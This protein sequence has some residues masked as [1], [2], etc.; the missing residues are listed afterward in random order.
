MNKIYL[1]ADCHFYHNNII[2]YES[3]PFENIV[4]MNEEL[5]FRWNKIVDDSDR[6]FVLGDFS[7]GNREQTTNILKRLNGRKI[8]IMGNHDKSRSVKWW[9]EVGFHE[10]CSNPIILDE[11][12][13]LSH[14]PPTYYNFNTPYFYIYGHVHSSE[15][16]P[17]VSAKS[18]CVSVERWNY[19]PVELN[20]IK[21]LVKA[22]E[23]NA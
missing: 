21:T 23:T 11:F 16:Y 17:T 20:T 6:V 3:R 12:L 13:V 2:K 1:I 4:H 8:L 9:L 7:F 19:E 18:C 5:I 15:L 14:E 10:V 22:L